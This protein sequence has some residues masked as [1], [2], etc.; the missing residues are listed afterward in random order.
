MENDSSREQL[1]KEVLDTLPWLEEASK[2]VHRAFALGQE[3]LFESWKTWDPQ[4]RET[5]LKELTRIDWE[6]LSEAI[7]ILQ[8]P[9]S[10]GELDID[11]IK[12]MPMRTVEEQVEH[13]AREE[14]LGREHLIKGKTAWLIPAGG[15]G[16]RLLKDLEMIYASLPFRRRY[17]VADEQMRSFDVDCAKG[18]LP[19]TPVLGK[20]F[21]GL[22]I[23]QALALGARVGRMPVLIFMLSDETRDASLFTIT[24]HPLYR[25]LEQALLLFDHGMNPVLDNQ[26]RIIPKD[27]RG[28]LVFSGNGNGGLF[29]AMWNTAY[30]G[31]PNI[32]SHLE[33][34][35]IEVVGFSNV[36]NPVADI[37]LPRMLGSHLRLG[38][39]LTFGVVRKVDPFERVGMIVR[40]AGENKLDKIEYNE[41]PKELAEETNPDDPD[42]LLYEHG[43]VNVFLMSLDE[44]KKVDHLPLK[45]YRNKM[46]ATARGR[47]SGNKFESFTFHI[48]RY[49][50]ADRIDVKEILRAEQFMPTKNSI[51]RD[52]PATVIRTLC[53]RNARWLEAQGA[54]VARQDVESCVGDYARLAWDLLEPAA[55]D[56][57][58]AGEVKAVIGRVESLTDLRTAADIEK[59]FALVVG[60]GDKALA[61]GLEKLK[62]AAD[63]AYSILQPGEAR[64]FAEFTPAFALEAEDLGE[65]GLG[66]DWVLETDCQLALSGHPTQVSIGRGLCLGENSAFILDIHSEYGEISLSKDRW[67]T[68]DLDKAGSAEI[69]EEV[70]LEPGAEVEIHVHGSGRVVVPDG[71]VFSGDYLVKVPDGE[72]VVLEGSPRI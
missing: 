41:F 35:G 71:T 4:Y 27:D 46:V 28:A 34:Q 65:M 18:Q 3:H 54:R 55:R 29:K 24:H 16:S 31:S 33:K 66:E 1:Q 61:A 58:L 2:L 67:L 60:L 11:R 36:D 53:D 12:P 5:L 64:A 59:L 72:T 49:P 13:R 68:F 20:T 70:R 17:K 39:S 10:A 51:G 25:Q 44:M 26:A 50:A 56:T 23:E 8:N 47:V 62:N 40:L 15:S 42:R 52:S 48:I 7:S 14:E 32:F 45:T 57:E 19:I 69:G 43:D 6:V 21:Y 30:K 22:F 37:I 63:H 9:S 38:V